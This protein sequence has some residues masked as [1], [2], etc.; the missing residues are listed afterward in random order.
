MR[1]CMQEIEQIPRHQ[2]PA[3][4]PALKHICKMTMEN[5]TLFLGER[6]PHAWK[7]RVLHN[8]KIW[9]P[10][11]LQL[12]HYAKHA[13]QL[14]YLKRHECYSCPAVFSLRCGPQHQPGS[15]VSVVNKKRL[16]SGIWLALLGWR[17]KNVAV[18]TQRLPSFNLGSH[19]AKKSMHD[20]TL[21]KFVIFICNT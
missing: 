16:L 17:V 11:I 3:T 13:N 14:L 2:N 6:Y 4:T 10:G 21:S 1:A 9:L 7:Q 15:A 12:N 18:T 20:P 5:L 8:K 19:E